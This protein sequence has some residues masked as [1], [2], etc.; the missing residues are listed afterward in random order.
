VIVFHLDGIS[1]VPTYR[2]LVVQ[3]ER[4][5]QLG[6]L[7]PGDRL[8]AVREVVEHLAINPN[9][10]FKAY[11]ELELKGLVSGRRGEG[12]FVQAD[13]ARR[14]AVVPA[15]ALADLQQRL[16]T[17][18]ELARSSGLGEREIEALIA[19]ALRPREETAA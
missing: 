3:V 15:E 17:W 10:V 18:L 8:P 11:R 13:A 1:G 5:L 12:T 14:V 4:A 9:T 16:A 6:R 2:Q 19:D 7:Q